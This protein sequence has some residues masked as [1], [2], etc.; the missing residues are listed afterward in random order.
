MYHTITAYFLRKEKY[1]L[2][3]SKKRPICIVFVLIVGDTWTMADTNLK[4][5]RVRNALLKQFQ[6][7]QYQPGQKLPTEQEL[8]QTLGVS[9]TTVRQ[10]LDLLLKQ[11]VIE[12]RQGSGT[13]FLGAPESE[14]NITPLKDEKGF[15]GLVNFSHMDYIYPEIVRGV[16]ETL[17]ESGYSLAI[18]PCNQN[19]EKEIQSIHR[20]IDQGVKGLIIEPSQNLQINEGHPISAI[21]RALEIPVVA[22][23]W[24]ITN[25]L[26]STV[27]VDDTIAG[28]NATKYLLGLGHRRIGIV[29]KS[30]V[31]SGYDR[32]LGYRRALAEAGIEFDDSWCGKYTLKEDI[33]G[34]LPAYELTKIIL[35]TMNPRPTAIFFFNDLTAMQGYRAI[36][37]LGLSIPDDISVL[38][39]DNYRSSALMY[40]PL[41]TYEHPKYELGRWA[42][43][44]LLSELAPRNPALHM[45][46]VFEPR[47]V[48]RESVR[49]ISP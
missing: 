12:K 25:Q 45:K 19:V 9:R 30:D 31:Q 11:R 35:A 24:G 27:T 8:T 47:L 5:Q 16:E 42:A 40:P 15:V 4:Y 6:D 18:A 34:T 33:P 38:G 39:F 21:I 10:G 20:L 26:V 48:E 41:T 22:T 32:Y 13:Y 7:N 3:A 44:I 29:I 1:F 49:G 28:Y 23:H 2:F 43:R 14:A 37:D 46:L 36:H 17:A